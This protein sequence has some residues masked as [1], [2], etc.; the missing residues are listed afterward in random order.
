MYQPVMHPLLYPLVRSETT[1]TYRVFQGPKEVQNRWV[2]NL[3]NMADGV[4]PPT[5]NPESAL[6]YDGQYE[7]ERCDAADAHQKTTAIGVFFDLLA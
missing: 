2:P 3:A 7:L 6:R 1:L 5:A 4:T